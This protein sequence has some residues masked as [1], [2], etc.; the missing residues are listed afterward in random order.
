MAQQLDRIHSGPRMFRFLRS[1]INQHTQKVEPWF[2]P[3]MS[4]DEKYALV[5]QAS[6]GNFIVKCSHFHAYFEVVMARPKK[7]TPT[8]DSGLSAATCAV[9]SCTPHGC[10][11]RSLFGQTVHGLCRCSGCKLGLKV[12]I[13]H[14]GNGFSVHQ[15]HRSGTCDSTDK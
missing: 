1:V 5:E 15:E 8:V 11:R 4:E 9:R 7:C 13:H 3:D 6:P 10:D 2:R 14:A 12:R